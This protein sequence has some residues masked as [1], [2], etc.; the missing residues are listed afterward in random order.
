MGFGR[1]RHTP[2]ASYSLA[3]ACYDLHQNLAITADVEA[4]AEQVP[5]RFHPRLDTEFFDDDIMDFDHAGVLQGI[6]DS[7]RR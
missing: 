6:N 2:L 3:D 1:Y 4:A 7:I 5:F